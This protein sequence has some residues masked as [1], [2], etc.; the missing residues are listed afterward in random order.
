M[1][2]EL[3]SVF[4]YGHA[5][6][7]PFGLLGNDENALSFALGYTFHECP[8]FLH[9]FLSEIGVGGI[10]KK[11]LADVRIDLQKHGG[12]LGDKGITDI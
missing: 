9:Q 11:A 7:T 3:P 5:V 1:N 10:R 8:F 4:A 6:D 2:M 12:N